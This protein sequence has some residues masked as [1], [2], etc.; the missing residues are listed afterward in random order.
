MKVTKKLETIWS[1]LEQ[2]SSNDQ[3]HGY[4]V[5]I[6]PINH[7]ILT[8]QQEMI[9]S[10]DTQGWNF[11]CKGSIKIWY[12][13]TIVYLQREKCGTGQL[14]LGFKVI[15]RPYKI[16]ECLKLWDHHVNGQ[17]ITLITVFRCIAT[18]NISENNKLHCQVEAQCLNRQ[19][20]GPSKKMS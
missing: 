11:H 6:A 14:L 5:Y 12:H 16:I 8:F 19:V 9:H 13:N 2:N 20:F 4:L 7:W 3:F 10:P 1:I 15:Y 18:S 17:S